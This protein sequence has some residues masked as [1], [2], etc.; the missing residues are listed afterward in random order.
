[1]TGGKGAQRQFTLTAGEQEWVGGREEGGGESN[2]IPVHG[3][4][5]IHTGHKATMGT[6]GE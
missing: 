3:C 6:S 4:T 2:N 1:M 5:C